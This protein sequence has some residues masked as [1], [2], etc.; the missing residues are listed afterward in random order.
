MVDVA[1]HAVREG[2]DLGHARELLDR[3]IAAAG[4]GPDLQYLWE[5]R[6]PLDLLAAAYVKEGATD[7]ARDIYERRLALERRYGQA[8][9]LRTSATVDR[10]AQLLQS[11]G[12][13]ASAAREYERELHGSSSKPASAVDRECTPPNKT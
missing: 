9:T 10:L 7:A 13:Y 4:T 6:K 5:V 12:D 3:V 2:G 1:Q 8:G 11:T